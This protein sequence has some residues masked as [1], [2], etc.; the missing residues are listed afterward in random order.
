MS[1]KAKI[2]TL[3]STYFN[4]RPVEA[5]SNL[6]K[7]TLSIGNTIPSLE[8]KWIQDGDVLIAQR[9]VC[10]KVS[11]QQ[12]NQLNYIFGEV[13]YIDGRPYLCRSLQVGG[14]SGVTN[15]WDTLL[16]KYG[17]DDILWYWRAEW[18]WGQDMPPE[19]SNVRAVRGNRTPRNWRVADADEL[20]PRIG[21]R[22]VLEPLSP[23]PAD[24]SP[25]LGKRIRLYGPENKCIS[26]ILAN[27]DT[28]D[29]VLSGA[30]ILPE[31][32]VW[33]VQKDGETIIQRDVI[34]WI[35]KE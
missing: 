26:G 3:G 23:A 31:K 8:L 27:A 30:C 11:W 13:I 22:P 33:V 24:F 14:L 12:L 29:L 34:N 16:D 19:M 9:C 10:T 28:Y 32:V 15:E 6:D 2:V 7:A 1:E 21:F 4:G 20:D 35:R 5:G 18:F 17:N 25:L